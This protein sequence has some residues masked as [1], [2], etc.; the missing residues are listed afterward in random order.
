MNRKGW[1]DVSRFLQ[2]IT[3]YTLT[4]WQLTAVELLRLL[5]ESDKSL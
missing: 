5:Q 4:I 3:E 2:I 1:R